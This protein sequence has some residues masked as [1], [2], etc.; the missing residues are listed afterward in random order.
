MTVY[1]FCYYATDDGENIAIYDMNTGDECF[2]GTIHD[3]MLGDFCDYEIFSYDIDSYSGKERN[4][5]IILNIDTSE[6]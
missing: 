5:Y 1:D 3:A 4:C 2:F 6:D